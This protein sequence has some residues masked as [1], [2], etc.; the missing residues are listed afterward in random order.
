MEF[1]RLIKLEHELRVL[2]SDRADLAR[3]E[4][5]MIEAIALCASCFEPWKILV[6]GQV[7]HVTGIPWFQVFTPGKE[8]VYRILY[9]PTERATLGWVLTRIIEIL[10]Y[11]YGLVKEYEEKIFVLKALLGQHIYYQSE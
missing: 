11:L 1:F 2:L 5:N 6:D 10:Y 3:A 8:L 9:H 7:T 4:A